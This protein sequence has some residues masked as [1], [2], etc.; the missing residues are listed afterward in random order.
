MI[1]FLQNIW[2]VH[3]AQFQKSKKKFSQRTTI[4]IVGEGDTE[5]AFLKYLRGLL[6]SRQAGNTTTSI[7]IKNAYG[8][9]PQ[10]VVTQVIRHARI[11]DYDYK[12]AFLD[13]DIPWSTELKK[14]AKENSI[15][16]IGNTPCIEATFLNLL[17]KKTQ[18]KNS[19]Q[20]KKDLKNLLKNVDFTEKEE[21]SSWCT[22]KL[23]HNN[24]KNNSD[25]NR[26]LNVFEGQLHL[27][28]ETSINLGHV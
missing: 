7:T 16:L 24:R 28:I 6:C 19:A 20:C 3:M 5:E 2:Q 23:L 14:Q 11:G 12:V 13:T 1:I 17:G 10:H 4:L 26:L 25:L 18:G 9:G 27:T 22:L 21:Y 15:I 8:K